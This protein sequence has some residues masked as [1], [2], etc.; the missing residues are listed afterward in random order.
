MI[1]E[2]LRDIGEDGVFK[3]PQV[4]FDLYNG[5]YLVGK[6]ITKE[7]KPRGRPDFVEQVEAV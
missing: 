1:T 5:K 7:D 2:K 6:V 3:K 4:F